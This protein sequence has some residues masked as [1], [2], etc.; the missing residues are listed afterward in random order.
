MRSC[1][2]RQKKKSLS[3][4]CELVRGEQLRSLII[5]LHPLAGLVTRGASRIARVQVPE[6]EAPGL[7]ATA[8]TM[9]TGP[10]VLNVYQSVP[11][12]K[13]L[14]ETWAMQNTTLIKSYD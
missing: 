9:T 4:L 5:F 8:T 11:Q 14:H 6:T 10:F 13:K 7:N 2:K 3:L 12:C 1:R